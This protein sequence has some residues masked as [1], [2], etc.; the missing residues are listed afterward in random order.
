MHRVLTAT[1]D[2]TPGPQQRIL[3]RNPTVAVVRLR[4]IG[5]TT[6]APAYQYTAVAAP[7]PRGPQDPDE[8]N[9]DMP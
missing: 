5:L 7:N 1:C 3:N 8:L 6:Y 4:M 9:A 2:R